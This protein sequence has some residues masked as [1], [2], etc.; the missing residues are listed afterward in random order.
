MISLKNL[1]RQ[2]L[3]LSPDKTTHLVHDTALVK[4]SSSCSLLAW[5]NILITVRWSPS[6]SFAFRPLNTE[7]SDLFDIQL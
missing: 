6:E 2:S 1:T 3:F 4:S 5:C 7:T